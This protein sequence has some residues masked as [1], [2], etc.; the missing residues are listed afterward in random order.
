VL[1][2]G[3]IRRTPPRRCE[4]VAFDNQNSA[5][6]LPERAPIIIDVEASGFGPGSYPIEVGIVLPDGTPH[7]FLITPERSW[8][9]WDP[10]AEADHGIQR[11]TLERYGQPAHD[12]AW[13]LNAL[14]TNN[15]VYSDAW[16]FDLSRIGLLFDAAGVPQ[17]FRLASI[18]ELLNERQRAVW[19][20]TRDKVVRE[21]ALRRHRA[22][23]DAR[24]LR[25]TLLRVQH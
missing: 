6:V 23:G 16:S 25:E 7:C 2:N 1:S 14:L 11:D 13:R 22:S 8:T 18:L 12:V 20:A 21:L 10:A 9:S 4:C 15:K 17:Q 19:H 3:K 5:P 24:I